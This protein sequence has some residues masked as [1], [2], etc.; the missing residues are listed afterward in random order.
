M[1]TI[2]SILFSCDNSEIVQK[3]SEKIFEDKAN[4]EATVDFLVKATVE[5][6]EKSEK[7]LINSVVGTITSLPEPT[8]LPLSLIHI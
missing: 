7:G 5:S 1:S 2:L 6:I 4:I 3:T 8:P